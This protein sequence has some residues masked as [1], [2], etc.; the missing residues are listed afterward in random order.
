MKTYKIKNSFDINDPTHLLIS[1]DKFFPKCAIITF[2]TEFIPGGAHTDEE[3]PGDE[4]ITV[5]W[6]GKRHWP[7][8]VFKKLLQYPNFRI[9][10]PYFILGT[11]DPGF[12]YIMRKDA[13]FWHIL[14]AKFKMKLLK[15]RRS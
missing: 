4:L 15:L 10:I 14:W 13:G 1:N 3:W 11:P 2:N 8:R 6:R 9:P 12:I 7:V 5:E